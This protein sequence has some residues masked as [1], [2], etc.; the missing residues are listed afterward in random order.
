M[1]QSMI[2]RHASSA[3]S[4]SSD[5][6]F[7]QKSDFTYSVPLQ[8]ESSDIMDMNEPLNKAQASAC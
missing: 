4:E 3:E 2:P 6:S 7:L 5:V 1:T 8:S